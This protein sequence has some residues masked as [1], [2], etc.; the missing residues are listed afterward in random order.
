MPPLESSQY[1]KYWVVSIC[2]C[3]KKAVEAC[4]N[5]PESFLTLSLYGWILFSCLTRIEHNLTI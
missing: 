5:F 3:D 2:G 1:L 4:I